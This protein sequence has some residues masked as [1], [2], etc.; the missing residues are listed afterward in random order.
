MTPLR[1]A[2]ALPA[3][4][5][6]STVYAQQQALQDWLTGP[7]A[8]SRLYVAANRPPY[9]AD[10][11]GAVKQGLGGLASAF[12][13]LTRVIPMHWV[14]TRTPGESCVMPGQGAPERDKLILDW[15]EPSLREHQGH[16]DAI[17]NGVLWLLQHRVDAPGALCFDA[18]RWRAWQ[19][20][21]VAVNQQYARHLNER[22]LASNQEAVVLVQDYHLY[23][24]PGLLR[25]LRPRQT[26]IAHFT[27]ICWPEPEQWI[28]LPTPIRQAIL[29]GM[30]GADLVGFQVEQD[31]QNFLAACTRFLGCEVDAARNSL[32]FED[33]R[34]QVGVYPISIDPL[35]VAQRAQ[36]A[37]V[38][39]HVAPTA[40]SQKQQW[41]LQVAR[42]DPSKNIV[43][44]LEAFAYLLR[45]KPMWQGRVAWLGLL[46]LSRQSCPVYRRY[47][48][49]IQRLGDRLNA[50]W[51]RPDWQPVSILTDHDPSRALALMRAYNVLLVNSIADGMNLVA[52]EGPI[53]N[54]QAGVLV[55]SETVGACQELGHT[56]LLV[57]P[58]DV[59]DT[60]RALEEALLMPLFKRRHALRQQQ[61][62]ILGNTIYAWALA[63]LR[64]LYRGLTDTPT[65]V[66]R[67]L[68]N[69]KRGKSWR[70]G[71]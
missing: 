51:G 33:R 42:T 25:A 16:Y 28:P 58:Y 35:D 23:L 4:P 34:I 63:Q 8:D 15:I 37:N 18:K 56:A 66:S 5:S 14:S 60:A 9:L 22:I 45:S 54:T 65:P 10:E 68:K 44:G 53:V 71:A 38:L 1:Q 46:P 39:A 67:G 43:R 24:L 20:G 6:A 17:A 7:G 27:H 52:K 62:Q 48:R 36:E 61:Q 49:K 41:I 12:A 19:E 55:L 59:I 13:S 29:K 31:R 11:R 50:R 70:V 57:N 30:L 2:Q 40:G 47:Y 64:D 69:Q 32:T 21:Y 3:W 26:R